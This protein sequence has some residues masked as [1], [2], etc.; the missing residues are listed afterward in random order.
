MVITLS[1]TACF[2]IGFVLGVIVLSVANW[3]IMP[4]IKRMAAKKAMK[5]AL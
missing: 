5:A 1:K 3:L 4:A 2:L